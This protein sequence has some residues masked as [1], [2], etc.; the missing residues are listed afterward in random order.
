MRGSGEGAVESFVLDE[1]TNLLTFITGS[2]SMRDSMRRKRDHEV[3]V[4]LLTSSTNTQL[5]L[6][7]HERRIL[8][9]GGAITPHA[10]YAKFCRLETTR[11][12]LTT[13]PSHLTFHPILSCPCSAKGVCLSYRLKRL[14]LCMFCINLRHEVRTAGL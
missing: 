11:L 14:D 6:P 7:P 2:H 10:D 12:F 1:P 5:S 8:V 13:R 9:Q 3:Q 4:P